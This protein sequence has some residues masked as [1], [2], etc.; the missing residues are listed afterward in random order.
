MRCTIVQTK[1]T[2]RSVAPCHTRVANRLLPIL[3][4]PLQ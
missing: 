2:R 1:T 4:R 3:R